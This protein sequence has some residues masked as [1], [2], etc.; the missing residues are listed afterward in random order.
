LGTKV[1]NA[2]TINQQEALLSLRMPIVRRCQERLCSVLTMA[3]PG[4]E[5]LAVRLFLACFIVFPDG[6]NVYGS[7]GGEFEGIGSV[8]RV[9]SCKIVFLG[10]TSFSLVQTLLLYVNNFLSFSHNTQRHRQTDGQTSVS[11]Q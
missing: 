7:S 6:S 1:S 5:S 3:I 4:V 10:G 9:E 8:Y 2:D 11:C